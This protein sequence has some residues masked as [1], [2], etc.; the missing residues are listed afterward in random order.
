MLKGPPVYVGNS[1]MRGRETR[2]VDAYIAVSHAI[3]E[4][5]RLPESGA[6]YEVIPNF[7]KDEPAA[8]IQP[9]DPRLDALPDEPFILQVGDVVADKGVHVLSRGVPRALAERSARAY[10]P[11]RA[12]RGRRR[13]G[14][15]DGSGELA[16]RS[17]T[18]R[19]EPQPV[20][21]HTLPVSRCQPN[22]HPRGHGR[23][24]AGHR[25]GSRRPSSI[26]STTV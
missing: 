2:A 25:V 20:R 21:H 18:S 15:R 16:A 14:G 9:A 12:G 4:A 26:R 24:P 1:A 7:Y 3:A 17:R 22:R 13:S 5:N 10:R 11:Q 8:D 23:R 6:R 19:V